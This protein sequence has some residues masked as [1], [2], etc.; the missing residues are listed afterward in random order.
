IGLKGELLMGRFSF[1]A[2][3][4]VAIGPNH[5][6]V[7]VSGATTN[8]SGGMFQPSGLLAVQG[9][10]VGRFVDN[11]FVIVPEFGVQAGLELF[12]GLRV[13]AGYNF[14]YINNVMR[15][16]DELNLNVNPRLV[17]ISR[18]FGALSGPAEPTFPFHK[19]DFY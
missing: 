1:G 16:G 11:S 9:V 5:E 14:L 10:N 19:T 2:R 4:T 17:P 15:P 6:V 3:G 18:A 12:P 13:L 8:S 7:D